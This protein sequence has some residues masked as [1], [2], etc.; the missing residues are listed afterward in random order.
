LRNTDNALAITDNENVRVFQFHLSE[1]FQPHNNIF[2][3]QHIENVKR[4]LSSGLPNVSPE[5]FY[6]K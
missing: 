5:I 3:P 6:T 4:Y 1:T 2:I